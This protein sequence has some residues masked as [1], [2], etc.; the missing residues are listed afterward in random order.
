[1]MTEENARY[2]FNNLRNDDDKFD[3]QWG[4]NDETQQEINFYEWCSQYDD[5]KHIKQT[6]TEDK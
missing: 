5:L 3:D 6:T 4:S 2:E 1:M